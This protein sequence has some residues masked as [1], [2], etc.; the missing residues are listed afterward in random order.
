VIRPGQRKIPRPPVRDLEA[1]LHARQQFAFAL[2]VILAAGLALA[3]ADT[4]AHYFLWRGGLT[5]FDRPS[6]RFSSILHV[7]V[8]AGLWMSYRLDP[9]RFLSRA[10]A[11]GWMAAATLLVST[12][13]YASYMSSRRPDGLDQ[14]RIQM[15]IRPGEGD[16]WWLE[17]SLRLSS[18]LLVATFAA[19]TV[20]VW[21]WLR[22]VR[23]A[24]ERQATFGES[25]PP[26]RRLM[27]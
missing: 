24:V 23:R 10:L 12:H 11:L 2:P 5:Q 7:C 16:G 13:F 20:I 15:G 27:S 8:V 21:I 14:L 9:K 6:V 1:A 26:R 25:I 4:Q 18:Q 3:I 22:S 19:I 17:W